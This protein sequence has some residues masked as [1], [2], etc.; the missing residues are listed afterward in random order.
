MF[1]PVSLY[2]CD[3]YDP[4]EVS[5]ALAKVLS[6]INGLSFIKPGMTIGIKANLVTAMA[7]E[8]AG[9][10]HPQLIKKLCHMITDL[11]A[12]VVI[13]DSPGG[14]YTPAFV[15]G[16]YRG[17]GLTAMLEDLEKSCRQR[18]LSRP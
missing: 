9:T 16:I 8:K 17:C 2:K 3:S 13:G 4:E 12:N 1:E 7:P 18:A 14:L 10:T 6:D 11:G 15:N 5:G